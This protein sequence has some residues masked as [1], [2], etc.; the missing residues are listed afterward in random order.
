[1]RLTLLFTII[2]AAAA[3]SASATVLTIDDVQPTT[4]V[5]HSNAIDNSWTRLFADEG[6]ATSGR[7]QSLT[8]P[9]AANGPAWLVETLTLDKS[10]AQ[11]FDTGSTL[12]MWIFEWN[13]ADDAND[14]SQWDNGDGI[15]GVFNDTGITNILVNGE[16]FD[17]GD[18]MI[19]DDEF[20][21]FNFDSPLLMD[22][23]TAYGI[24]FEFAGVDDEGN[25]F[26]RLSVSSPN[27]YDHGRLLNTTATANSGGAANQ[28]L[29]FFLQGSA[30]PEPST[31]ALGLI[32]LLGLAWY[33][34]RRK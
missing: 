7:G 22:P 10:S 32:G 34:W 14:L 18:L 15:G 29:T 24:Y 25:E 33:A 6:T 12:S 11:T 5:I 28:D 23:A 3:T 13:P 27:I 17:I 1:M 26:L 30:V 19:E 16:S 8:L 21:H 20:L 31:L 4:D 2:L 9:G